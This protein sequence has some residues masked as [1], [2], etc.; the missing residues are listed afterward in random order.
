MKTTSLL[1]A[2]ATCALVAIGARPAMAQSTAKAT[3]QPAAASTPWAAIPTG[4]YQL[5]IQLEERVMAAMLTI[6]DSSGVP[7]ATFLGEN[8]PEAHPMR[9]TVKGTEL[10]LN[11]DAPKGPMEIVILRQGEQL[12]GRWSYNGGTGTL[13]GKVEK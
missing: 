3:T 13:T 10:Y 7:A 11:A 8:D 6:R 1:H 12:N 5:A 2:L 9:A 4:K